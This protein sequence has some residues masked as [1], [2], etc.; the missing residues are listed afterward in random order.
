MWNKR[1]WMWEKECEIKETAELDGLK[2]SISEKITR[3]IVQ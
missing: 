1:K 3:S 2:F